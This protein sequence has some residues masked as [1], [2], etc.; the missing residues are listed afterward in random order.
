MTWL[1]PIRR[2][3]LKWGL[4][5]SAR[6]A[7]QVFHHSTRD[8]GQ[9]QRELLERILSLNAH[10]VFGRRHGFERLRGL[11]E[12]ASAVPIHDY[13]ALRPLVER[14]LHGEAN[15]LTAEPVTMFAMTSGTTGE[16]KYIPVTPEVDRRSS[17]LMRMWLY[18]CLRSHPTC[19]DDGTAAIA[20]PAVESHSPS[21][22][23]CGNVSGRIQARIPRFIKGSYV[24]PYE[25]MCIPD[26]EE[27]YRAM[28]RFLYARP[29]SAL[30]TPNAAT[31]LRIAQVASEHSESLIRGIHDGT[32]GWGDDRADLDP[33]RT[34]LTADPDLARDLERVHARTGSLRP[35]D[36]W[37]SLQL[38]GCWLGGSAGIQV[39]LLREQYGDVVM[40]DLGYL[41]SEGRMSLPL[42]DGTAAGVLALDQAFYEFIPVDAWGEPRGEAVDCTALEDGE[43]YSILLT[44]FGGL[45]RYDI[46]DIVRVSGWH[47]KTPR[48]E[49]VRKGK[50]M[51]NLQ[52]EKL[53]V[54]HLLRAVDAVHEELGLRLRDYRLCPRPEGQGYLF[55]LEAPEGFGKEELGQLSDVLDRT[56]GE[57]NREYQQK[58][59]SRRLEPIQVQRMAPG[60]R[61]RSTR[62]LLERGRSDVQFKWRYLFPHP[63]GPTEE[64]ALSC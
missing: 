13:E 24:V 19:F 43:E 17:G 40:R 10:T 34:M 18:G 52:G 30:G 51:V 58:R 3:V 5:L 62:R 55:Q 39:G 61:E 1:E 23:P 56:L 38:I 37:R 36:A 15:V 9:A 45:Y 8:P 27:R 63:P 44:T 31:L 59:E 48:I 12:Y 4:E 46:N 32:L 16:P 29:P 7:Y 2:Q 50:D 35:R 49:F 28:A 22:I 11:A 25:A 6:R 42:E 54:N 53:H 41:A 60:W 57:Q 14:H 64:V 47:Q 33:L 26:Y 20:S 21:G